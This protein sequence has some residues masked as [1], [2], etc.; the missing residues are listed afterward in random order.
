GPGGGGGPGRGPEGGFGGG[1]FSA[2]GLVNRMMEFDK[3]AD[4]KL[5]KDELPVRMQVLMDRA[6]ANKDGFVDRAELTEYAKKQIERG[7]A[8]GQGDG[9]PRRGGGGPRRPPGRDV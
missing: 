7:P 3:N 1:A 6:D 4:G 9:P 2:E 5:A 8:P